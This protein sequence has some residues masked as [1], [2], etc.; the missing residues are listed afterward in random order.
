[1]AALPIRPHSGHETLQL[2]PRECLERVP[3]ACPR[4]LRL[5]SFWRFGRVQPSVA[6]CVAC[7]VAARVITGRFRTQKQGLGRTHVRREKL[8]T[9]TCAVVSGDDHSMAVRRW[10]DS[11]VI[12]LGLCPWAQ[13]A[14][15]AG[16]IRIVTSTA[17]STDGVLQDLLEEARRLSPGA[18]REQ[19]AGPAGA[20]NTTLLVCPLVEGWEDFDRFHEFYAEDLNNGNGLMAEYALKV[21]AFHPHCEAAGRSPVAGDEVALQGGPDGK[22]LLGVV[23]APQEE[24]GDQLDTAS[25][26]VD[27]EQFSVRI[28]GIILDDESQ[29]EGN[30]DLLAVQP[31]PGEPQIVEVRLNDIVWLLGQEANVDDA[32]ECRSVIARAPR[33]VLH[34]LRLKDLAGVDDEGRSTVYERNERQVREVGLEDLE[35]MLR[36]C[37]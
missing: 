16:S 4:N 9:V 7:T 14:D 18:G 3:L 17:T 20:T 28:E 12:G 36:R 24:G 13:P 22:L 8:Q 29:G 5:S 19:S 32:S 15:E 10:L 35:E 34:L 11:M 1:M 21:V 26:A 6:S 23:L 31:L 27:Q 2:F 33:P 30:P 25:Q 37:A